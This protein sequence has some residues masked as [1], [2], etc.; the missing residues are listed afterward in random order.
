MQ[1][2]VDSGDPPPKNQNFNN[3]GIHCTWLYGT[4]LPWTGYQGIAGHLQATFTPQGI[5]PKRFIFSFA[6][7]KQ[8]CLLI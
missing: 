8:M 7:K 5:V 4:A 3:A 2:S 6:F 1:I